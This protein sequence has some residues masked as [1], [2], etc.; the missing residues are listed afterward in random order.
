MKYI[1]LLLVLLTPMTLFAEEIDHP[2]AVSDADV[3]N[4]LTEIS[5]SSEIQSTVFADLEGYLRDM[6]VGPDGTVYVGITVRM[7]RGSVT[8]IM[9]LRDEDNDGYAEVRVPFAND[10]PGTD[11]VFHDGYLY[12]G[13]KTAIY[14]FSIPEGEYLPDA[15]PEVVVDGFLVQ[16][17]HDSKT[18]AIDDNHNLY[19]N[20]GA[21]S[22]ACQFEF[23]TR[24]SQGQIPC[25]QLELQAGIWRFSAD[26]LNQIHTEDGMRVATGIRNAI[27]IEWDPVSEQ[28]Y[29]LNHGR[30]ALNILFPEYFTAEESAI[31]PSEEMHVLTEGENYGWPYTYYDH[32]QSERMLAPEYGGDGSTV[33]DAR[34]N[35]PDPIQAFPGHWAP[36]DIHFYQGDMFPSEFNDG[37]FVVFHGSWNRAPLP[38][39]G[40]KVVFVPLDDQRKP[41]GD[42]F[43]V[44]D[45][46]KGTDA[47][48]NPADAA[49]RPTGMT[50]GLDGEL[51]ISSDHNVDGTDDINGR[52]WKITTAN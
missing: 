19:V 48:L 44:L 5:H 9:A 47:L 51:Y 22:N 45:G 6:A 20:V 11:L 23:R 50:E 33:A 34:Y 35:Y 31:L 40:Y 49:H 28:V 41:M 30:D 15:P 27:A 10:I 3:V 24:G 29:F 32:I 4:E 16:R 12:F 8:G 21:P 43:T 7:G 26:E 25:P 52:I 46:F 2:Y 1:R 17:R 38:Q 14:R 42:W 39:D 37:A 18:F 13:S 36:N